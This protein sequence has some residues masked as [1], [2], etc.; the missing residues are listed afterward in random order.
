KKMG[1]GVLGFVR[2]LASL[3]VQLS[4]HT[5]ARPYPF[6][7]HIFANTPSIASNMFLTDSSPPPPGWRLRLVGSNNSV[8]A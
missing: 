7:K 2:I 4:R 6:A 3:L 5:F 8:K 1:R